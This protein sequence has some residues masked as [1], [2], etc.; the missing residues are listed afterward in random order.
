MNIIIG[1]IY[2]VRLINNYLFCAKCIEITNT[3]VTFEARNGLQTSH[4]VDEIK[5][6]HPI[7]EVA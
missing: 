1:K 6:I 4:L 5:Y 3:R 7:H 2:K